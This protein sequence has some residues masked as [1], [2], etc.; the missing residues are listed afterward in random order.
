[1]NQKSGCRYISIKSSLTTLTGN[2]FQTSAL[3]LLALVLWALPLSSAQAASGNISIDLTY[4]AAGLGYETG[5]ATVTLG[6]KT[7]SY[8]V[9]GF[10]FLGAGISN[11]KGTGAVSGAHALND[12]NGDFSVTRGSL[13]AIVGGV[14]MSLHN[15][16][17][18]S[19]NLSGTSTGVDASMGPGKLTFTRVGAIRS[20]GGHTHVAA[21]S[22]ATSG[23]R[24]GGGMKMGHAMASSHAS[25]GHMGFMPGLDKGLPHIGLY[26][27]TMSHAKV[28][29]P[30]DLLGGPIKVGLV[31]KNTSIRWTL[32]GPRFVDPAVFGTPA[33]PVGWEQAPF[34]LIGMQPSWLRSE[35][36]K[37]TFVDHATPFS[38]WMTVGVGSVKMNLVDATAIDGARTKDKIDFDATFKSPDGKFT[39]RV[40]VKKALPHG[41]GYPFFGGVV[42]NHLLHGGTAIGTR[43]MPTEFTYA[44]FWGVGKVYRNGKLVNDGQIIHMMI[45]EFVRGDNQDLQFDGGV[46]PHGVTM[47]L[48]VPPYKVT[49]HGPV[50]APVKTGYAPFPAIKKLMM[51]KMKMLKASKTMTPAQKKAAKKRMMEVKALMARTK[52]S[53]VQAMMEGDKFFGQPFL[54][55]MFGMRRSDLRISH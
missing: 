13:A 3:S 28:A 5:T 30:P 36:G 44:G 51:A 35:Y 52:E 18:V 33:H 45:G 1:M 31:K 11:F 4:V 29:N 8:K 40:V 37:Y 7:A 25:G 26:A 21:P 23:A 55:V 46:D 6:G 2:I 41:K 22:H 48:M 15:R 50:L 12:L 17:G 27:Y 32:P 20:T 53:M 39:Y 54:H 9:K 19:M 34:P 16:R 47:H 10:Q 49:P 43:L 38:D 14:T 24:I 42:T